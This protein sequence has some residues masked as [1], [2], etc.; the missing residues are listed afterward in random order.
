MICA[1]QADL[2]TPVVAAQR[3]GGTMR[4][5]VPSG[6]ANS[7]CCATIYTEFNKGI[8]SFMI[9]T[10]IHIVVL[11]IG[12]HSLRFAVCT[13][14]NVIR[15]RWQLQI[16]AASMPYTAPGPKPAPRLVSRFSFSYIFPP[17]FNAPP[18]VDDTMFDMNRWSRTHI[19]PWN[20]RLNTERGV[21]LERVLRP[22]RFCYRNHSKGQHR[23]LQSYGRHTNVCFQLFAP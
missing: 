14:N 6:I 11:R 20:R 7:N 16:P 15:R 23:A 21:I 22:R 17:F 19:N 1:G 2:V 3:A 10:H 13:Y 5:V 12:S 9:P 4:L 8:I 18:L